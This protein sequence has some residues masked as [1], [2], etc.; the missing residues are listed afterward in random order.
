MMMADVFHTG[1][2]NRSLERPMLIV[3]LA[4]PLILLDSSR[5]SEVKCSSFRAEK[6]S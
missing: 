6:W 3:I 2:K 5:T 1:P 4:H